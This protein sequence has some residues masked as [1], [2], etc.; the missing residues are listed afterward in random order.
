MSATQGWL[1]DLQGPDGQC[2]RVHDVQHLT[3]LCRAHGL[4]LNNMRVLV[5]IDR[6][7]LKQAHKKAHEAGWVFRDS[8]RYLTRGT[9]E[10]VP[11]VGATFGRD[12]GKHFM[13]AVVA[14]PLVVRT[15]SS[16]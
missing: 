16:P 10:I 9:T 14:R 7:N 12:A 13:V 5:G 1:C 6:G 8:V 11:T 2:H 3:A 4:L 15:C